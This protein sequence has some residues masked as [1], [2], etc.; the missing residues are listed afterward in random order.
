MNSYLYKASIQYDGKTLELKPKGMTRTDE[1]YVDIFLD[2]IPNGRKYKLDIHT[3]SPIVLEN[4]KLTIDC[5]QIKNTNTIFSNGFQSWS[6]SREFDFN[7]EIPLLKS[8]VK[9]LMEY[10]GDYHFPQIKKGKGKI[11]SWTYTYLREKQGENIQLWASVNERTGYTL[12]QFDAHTQQL[13]IEKDCNGLELSHSYPALEIVELFGDDNQVFEQWFSYF[14]FSKPKVKPAFGWTS[15]YNY[16]TKINENI[17]LENLKAFKEKNIDIDIFQIDD[18]YQNRVGDWLDANPQ[19]FPNGMSYIARSIHQENVKAGLWLA[20]YIVEKKSKIFNEKKHWIL[21]NEKGKMVAAGYNPMW[22]GYFYA[23]D[24]YH[25]EVREYLTKVFHTILHQWNFDMVKLDF[26]YAA[27]LLPRTDK[28]RGQIMADAME[29]LRQLCG[30][31]IILGCGVPLGP[32]FGNVDY[33]RIGAD[34]HLS[35]EHGLLKFVN[36]R[37][38]VSTMIALRSV[39]GRWQLNQRAFLNDPDVFILRNEK[40]KLT[41]I[42]QNTILTVNTILGKLIFTSDNINNYTDEQLSELKA[43]QKWMHSE[44]E[45]VIQNSDYYIIRFKNKEENYQAYV[46]LWNKEVQIKLKKG[47]FQLEPYE[48]LILKR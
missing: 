2:E 4:I 38:R 19:K 26:L 47:A 18:G 36:N 27:A 25:P 23:L 21:K 6:E 12:F 45:K 30:D 20:P 3:K 43:A 17:I 29:F 14:N 10:Y 13:M 28:T 35:W 46:N 48:T 1:F 32:S 41:P 8:F 15:W 5:S 24:I 16:Y 22:S 34:I 9:P 42:Q 33:C 44:V 11:H 39:L 40:N 31:K 37:E 7:E